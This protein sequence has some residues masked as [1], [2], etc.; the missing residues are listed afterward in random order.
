MLPGNVPLK[1]CIYVHLNSFQTQFYVI[2]TLG[3]LQ[4][5]TVTVLVSANYFSS[6]LFI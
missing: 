5:V 2:V 6:F 3:D 4:F 1:D